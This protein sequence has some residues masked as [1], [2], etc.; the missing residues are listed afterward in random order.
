MS[1]RLLLI[2]VALVAV[3]QGQESPAIA[4]PPTA[5]GQT[6]GGTLNLVLAN[7]NGFVLA[8]DSRRTSLNGS[9]HWDDSQ[10]LFR[11]GKRSA[12]VISGFATASAPGTPLDVQVAALLRDHFD[13]RMQ[14]R[15][16]GFDGPAL[17]GWMRVTMASELQVVGSVFATLGN[18]SM[19]MTAIAAGY[20]SSGQAKIAR[21]DF[22]PQLSP[23]GPMVTLLPTFD[24]TV[25]STTV[26]SFTSASSGINNIAEAV[27]SGSYLSSD[28]RIRRFYDARGKGQ[29]DELPLRALCQLAE[30]IL[31]ETEKQTPIVGGPNQVAVFPH[32]G[33]ARWLAPEMESSRQKV[34][35]SI[36]WL[37][38]PTNVH[39]AD[40]QHFVG[41][42]SIYEDQTHPI[43]EEYRQVFVAGALRDVDVSLDGNIFAG[44]LFANVTFKYRGGSF[45]F[46][47]SNRVQQCEVEVE[48]GKGMPPDVPPLNL[49]RFVQKA[50]IHVDEK[51]VGTPLAPSANGCVIPTKDGTLKIKTSGRYKGKECR[52]SQITLPMGIPIPGPRSQRAE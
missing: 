39:R 23:F 3:A 34:V 38:G 17:T 37:G 21:F 6:S 28:P 8:A 14:R 19:G 16:I 15:G 7:G 1:R 41:R 49:C 18:F 47:P 13:A 22:K 32:R 33:R 42:V 26:T 40:G 29:L 46:G 44:F 11:V 30:A 20:D 51:T 12:L 24:T 48:E 36:L 43:I 27:L 5:F 50:A 4:A 9:H 25:S 35:R 52:G 10:K 2:A 31:A 45:W